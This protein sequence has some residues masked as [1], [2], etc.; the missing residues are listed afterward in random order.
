M[1]NGYYRYKPAYLNYFPVPNVEIQTE[2]SLARLARY[3]MLL[4]GHQKK[5][6]EV[7]FVQVIDGLVFEI[8]FPEEIKKAGKEILEHIGDLKPLKEEMSEE[9]K[10]AIIEVEF[11]RLYD[12]SH[13]VRNHIET[14]DSVEVV[15]IIR[16]ALN[17]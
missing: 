17:K 10:L 13:P 16:S 12:P 14:L 7:F 3:S 4:K 2:Q 15:R 1:A 9:E 11:D 5:L 8:Y 6:I